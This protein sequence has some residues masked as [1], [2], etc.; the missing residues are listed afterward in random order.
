[1]TITRY[2]FLYENCL[3]YGKSNDPKKAS[4]YLEL[5]GLKVSINS[6]LEGTKSSTEKPQLILFR[7]NVF[8][9]LFSNE[10]ST[11]Y[12]WRKHL[13]NYCVL[14]NFYHTYTVIKMLGKGSYGRV[15]LVENSQNNKQFAVKVLDKMKIC[16]HTKGFDSL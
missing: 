2:Y 13:A 3:L 9:K 10:Q 6:A 15:F 8:I 1:M 14:M 12:E 5:K 16:T 7:S 4:K 11:I